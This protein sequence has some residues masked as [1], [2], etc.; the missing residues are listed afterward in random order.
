M[1][2]EG[3]W[4]LVRNYL[5]IVLRCQW[6]KLTKEKKK[7]WRKRFFFCVC[8]KR[9]HKKKIYKWMMIHILSKCLKSRSDLTYPIEKIL[10]TF[11]QIYSH[12]YSEQFKDFFFP[13]L[14]FFFPK[15]LFPWNQ[16]ILRLS[17]LNNRGV[18]WVSFITSF[19]GKTLEDPEA[20]S[21]SRKA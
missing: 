10:I 2:R 5:V 19:G 15:S 21:S 1:K 12:Y 8:E 6:L 14:S 11:F 7:Y 16:G 18:E 20:I 4:V 17:K 3:E 13:L 9:I